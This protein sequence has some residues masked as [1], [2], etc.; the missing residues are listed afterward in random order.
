MSD[1]EIEQGLATLPE[2]NSQALGAVRATGGQ[3]AT[4]PDPAIVK[5][6]LARAVEYREM[7]NDHIKSQFV[8]DIHYYKYHFLASCKIV[9][10]KIKEHLSPSWEITAR[11]AEKL[12]QD[13][14]FFTDFKTDEDA[15]KN[16][17]GVVGLVCL[18]C[19]IYTLEGKFYASGRGN[20]KTGPY[21]DENRT[22]KIAKKRALIDALKSSGLIADF[23]K[24]IMEKE[25]EM[26]T[27][28]RKVIQGLPAIKAVTH[29]E[30]Q[31]SESHSPVE[32]PVEAPPAGVCEHCKSKSKYH[33]K[34]CPNFGA[35]AAEEKQ[36]Y[37]KT[38][39]EAKV[40]EKAIE[41]EVVNVPAAKAAKTFP[42]RGAKHNSGKPEDQVMVENP[43]DWC[44]TEC[45]YSWY[46][47]PKK[48]LQERSTEWAKRVAAMKRNGAAVA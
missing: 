45:E 46:G 31:V 36:E 48:S 9:N 3:L 21:S 47:P 30:S 42:C 40:A 6:R 43:G 16:F 20:A 34:T 2:N 15:K 12:L 10:C 4:L 7:I 25:G 17:P 24:V 39:E 28:P 11:G 19:F 23:T 38:V 18:T 29:S 41:G 37:P 22:V 32:K 44:S 33:A 13:F 27:A 5:E 14:T 26:P 35:A 8:K 1:N